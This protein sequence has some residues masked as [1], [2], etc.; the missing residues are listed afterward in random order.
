MIIIVNDDTYFSEREYGFSPQDEQ[1]VTQL[2]WGGFIALINNDINNGSLAEA[3]PKICDDPDKPLPIGSDTNSVYLAL[4][5]EIPSA[6]SFFERTLNA[7]V[8]PDTLSALDIV[9]F[10]YRHVSKPTQREHHSFYNHEHLRSFDKGGGQREYLENINRLF[11]RNNLA[12][13]LNA[14]GKVERLGPLILR[15]TLTTDTFRTEDQ[16]LNRLLEDARMKIGDP[17]LTIRRDAIEKLWDAWER[18]KTLEPGTDKKQQIKALLTKAFPL[19]AD[20]RAR[21]DK[22]AQA[23]TDLGNDFRIRHSE[24]NKPII[25]DPESVDYLFYR[26]FALI[27]LL[28]RKTN[29][30]G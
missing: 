4:K 8:L 22:E 15:D 11:R 7:Y 19:E 23:L 6:N 16:E 2:F 17:D 24:T 27:Q 1:E 26:L 9:E 13:E 28:L 14:N 12:Y 20:L 21:I 30:G 25:S 29:R 5:A 10:F 3:F 18:L